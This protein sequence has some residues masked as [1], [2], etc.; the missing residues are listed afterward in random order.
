MNKTM[1]WRGLTSG[2]ITRRTLGN[3][4]WLPDAGGECLDI[5]DL[6]AIIPFTE[7]HGMAFKKEIGWLLDLCPA[8][9]A[10]AEWR[11]MITLRV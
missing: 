9:T 2:V 7:A 6:K 3:P 1:A 4:G 10:N 5:R 8:A 11:A